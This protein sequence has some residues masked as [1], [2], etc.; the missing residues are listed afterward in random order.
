MTVDG[1]K[2][3]CLTRG[4]GRRSDT[5]FRMVDL[6]AV[7]DTLA[8]GS[9][10]LLEGYHD[11]EKHDRFFSIEPTGGEMRLLY[12]PGDRRLDLVARA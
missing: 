9:T 5:V 2:P 3:T 7:E 1:A 8:T 12:A 4:E 6:D 10:L 11:L